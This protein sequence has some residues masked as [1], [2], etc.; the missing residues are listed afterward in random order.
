M[1]KTKEWNCKRG[2]TAEAWSPEDNN[3]WS[4]CHDMTF[5]LP[6]ILKSVVDVSHL[7]LLTW[8]RKAHSPSRCIWRVG[9]CS[10]AQSCEWPSASSV[11]QRRRGAAHLLFK[12]RRPGVTHS[13]TGYLLTLC[14]GECLFIRGGSC[15]GVTNLFYVL[16]LPHGYISYAW[17]LP[18][19]LRE[20]HDPPSTIN[21]CIC[22]KFRQ[23]C[24]CL[25]PKKKENPHCIIAQ[26]VRALQENK[27][28]TLHIRPT[29]C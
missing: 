27:G 28:T 9:S 4:A 1:N 13:P 10:C 19:W 21:K 8:R 2:L 3:N 29:K 24:K 6:F 14:L 11:F 17:S 7:S 25:V 26:A 20:I 15:C 18:E 23:L 22:I 12:P 16:T 5:W